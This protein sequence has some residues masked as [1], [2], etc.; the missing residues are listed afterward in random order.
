MGSEG[1]E[2]LRRAKRARRLDLVDMQH[3]R[4]KQ[5]HLPR[6]VYHAPRRNACGR[7][8]RTAAV[9]TTQVNL[10]ALFA[11]LF[12]AAWIIGALVQ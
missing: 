6:L 2:R 12:G 3:L 11:F 4:G 7:T 5:D 9:M 10:P 8:L 1:Y